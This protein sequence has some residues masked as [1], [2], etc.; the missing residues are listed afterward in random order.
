MISEGLPL[1]ASIT[2]TIKGSDYGTAG[3]SVT[4]GAK[5][6]DPEVDSLV[7]SAAPVMTEAITVA[8]VATTV[9]IPADISKD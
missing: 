5:S 9:A 3:G 1:V 8:T 6:A 2:Q 4:G 7:R